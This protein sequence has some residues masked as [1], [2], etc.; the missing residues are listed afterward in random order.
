[1]PRPSKPRVDK[2]SIDAGEPPCEVPPSIGVVPAP[3]LRKGSLNSAAR[4]LFRASVVAVSMLVAAPAAAPAQATDTGVGLSPTTV[5]TLSAGYGNNAGGGATT[6]PPN[7][8]D[9]SQSAPTAQDNTATNSQATRTTAGK[10]GSA[11]GGTAGPSRAAGDGSGSHGGN[12]YAN[13]GNAESHSNFEN[14]QSNQIGGGHSSGPGNGG[15]GDRWGGGRGG[16]DGFVL[17]TT[18]PRHPARAATG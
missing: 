13:G 2:Y 16:H 18:K 5:D 9:N 17:E 14:E 1:M 4:G 10:G 8:V 12:A 6:P 3:E 11:A 15:G 7:P